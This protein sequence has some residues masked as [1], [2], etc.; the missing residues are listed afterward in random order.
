MRKMGTVARVPL[1]FLP[2]YYLIFFWS[3]KVDWLSGDARQV[4]TVKG[5][6]IQYSFDRYMTWSS[7]FW[8]EGATLFSVRHFIVFVVLSLAACLMLAYS[9]SML[10]RFDSF[11]MNCVLVVFLIAFFP[12]ASLSSA[13]WIATI[14]NYLWPLSLFLCA[15][16]GIQRSQN[17]Q[18]GILI[19]ILATI[20]LFLSVFSEI[21][22]LVA[23]ITFVVALFFYKKEILTWFNFCC[24]GV[25]GF[26]VLNVLFCPGNANRKQSE[27]ERW[28]PSFHNFTAVD[29]MTI[30]INHLG[31]F[32][33]ESSKLTILCLMTA[34]L[35]L[36][37]IKNKNTATIVL[38]ASISI[39]GISNHY[40]QLN[41]QR[42]AGL[43]NTAQFKVA[44][45]SVFWI[46]ALAFLFNVVL[47]GVA[48]Y[49]LYGRTSNGVIV[50]GVPVISL[51]ATLASSESPTL[52]ASMDRP[53]IFLYI[54]LIA[55]AAYVVKTITDVLIKPRPSDP[56]Q[57]KS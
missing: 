32:M 11:G 7:R 3:S 41:T 10:L 8:I 14:V 34:L 29:R 4:S 56:A 28:F 9:L 5:S 12:I 20:F 46:S 52:I 6:S 2:V 23:A 57:T 22:A 27:I 26:G 31:V 39:Q 19:K 15:L 45:I 33:S 37:V 25:I 38:V 55:V 44:D 43:I 49:L 51:L 21:L 42:I 17:N 40:F 16:Y 24:A 47:I 48:A 50:I 36:S 18:K 35:I 13:G 30:Q 1:F 54:A 53:F